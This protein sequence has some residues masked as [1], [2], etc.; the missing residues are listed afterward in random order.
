MD[1]DINVGKFEI[2]ILLLCQCHVLSLFY[3]TIDSLEIISHL[4]YMKHE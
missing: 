1:M 3:S 2:E 4:S